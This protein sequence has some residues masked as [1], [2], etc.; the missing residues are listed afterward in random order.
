M[1]KFHAN[2]QKAVLIFLMSLCKDQYSI[3]S[4]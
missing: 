1:E 4:W 3:G 2:I